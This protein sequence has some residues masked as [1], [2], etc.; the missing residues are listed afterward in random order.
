VAAAIDAATAIAGAVTAL[1]VAPQ[2][3]REILRRHKTI[4]SS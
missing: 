2:R 4:P 3:M 1:P